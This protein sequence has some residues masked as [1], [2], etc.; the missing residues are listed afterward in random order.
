MKGH[1][2][3]D[4]LYPQPA[5]DDIRL[6]TVLH[7]LSDPGRVKMVQV[8]A[9]GEYHACNVTEFGLDITKSTLSHHLKT[10]R[11]AGLTTIDIRGRNK[12]IALRTAD[13]EQRFPGLISALTSPSAINDLGREHSADQT[14][15]QTAE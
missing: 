6:T 9:D 10:M 3:P 11:E 8:L 1:G 13:L 14:A 15:A 7:V 5:V 12:S 4:D 2:M